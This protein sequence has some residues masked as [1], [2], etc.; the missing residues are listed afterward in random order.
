MLPTVISSQASAQHFLE[1]HPKDFPVEVYPQA[2]AGYYLAY[3]KAQWIVVRLNV[4]SARQTPG[5]G[6][7]ARCPSGNPW[8]PSDV[9]VESQGALGGWGEAGGCSLPA[10]WQSLGQSR[11][12]SQP[13]PVSGLL[14]V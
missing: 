1:G 2:Q 12:G 3:R 10:S 7:Q 14:C 5:S 11:E 8:P 13:S 4:L 6:R 9:S